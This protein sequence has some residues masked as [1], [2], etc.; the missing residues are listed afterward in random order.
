MEGIKKTEISKWKYDPEKV[1]DAELIDDK[2]HIGG[3]AQDLQ[4]NLGD[5]VS[6]GKM[7]D[8]ISAVGISMAATKALAKKV[9]KLEKR[10]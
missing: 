6:N 3:M 4:K 2:E 8:I 1:Q 9:D 10:K 7:V 5:Q